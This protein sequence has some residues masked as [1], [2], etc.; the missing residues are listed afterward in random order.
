MFKNNINYHI[1]LDLDNIF[2]KN[3]YINPKDKSKYQKN[4]N[5]KSI[6]LIRTKNTPIKIGDCFLEKCSNL[7]TIDLSHLSQV[8]RIGDW[9]LYNC[10]SLTTIDLSPLSQ[11]TQIGMFFLSGCSNLTTIDLSHLSQ[12]TQIGHWFLSR[13]SNLTTIDLSPLSQVTQFAEYFLSQCSRLTTIDLSHLSRVTQIGD[14][15]LWGCSNLTTIDLSHLSQVTQIGN[16]FLSYCSSLTTIDLSPLSQVTQIDNWFL[17][18]CSK[19]TTIICDN[20]IIIQ[21]IKDLNIEIKSKSDFIFSTYEKDI[22]KIKSNKQYAKQV[23]DWLDIHYHK[24]NS[25]SI[26]IKK[27]EEEKSEYN[28]KMS[29]EEINECLNKEEIFSME[30][31]ENIP[32]N[33][34]IKVSK[35][36]DKY[37]CF[38]IVA[39]RNFIFKKQNDEYKNP[40]TNKEFTNEDINNILKADIKKIRYF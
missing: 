38:D 23:L 39:L 25:H 2:N 26:L 7:T 19:L 32:K 33:K 28:K 8:T 37:Y 21:K 11:V 4:N 18:Y 13:C 6:K 5:V 31:L 20:D 30:P 1:E 10:S 36:N 27:I 15:F 3:G 14:G 29:E 34:L 22:G 12:V 24:R 9:F 16:S 35:V 17:Y 40:Y